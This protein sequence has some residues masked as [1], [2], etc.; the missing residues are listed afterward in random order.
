MPPDAEP[1][2]ETTTPPD[3]STQKAPDNMM[4]VLGYFTETSEQEKLP[5]PDAGEGEPAGDVTPEP[6]AAPEGDAAGEPAEKPA[7]EGEPAKPVAAVI[8]K[9]QRATKVKPS[10]VL[11]KPLKEQIADAVREG[12]DKRPES[13]TTPDPLAK[14]GELHPAEKRALELAQF[15]ARTSPEKYKDMEAKEINFITKHREYVQSVVNEK[16]T[17]TTEDAQ[18][19]EYQKLLRQHKPVYQ[20]GDREELLIQR[21]VEKGLSVAEKRFNEE[22]KA[23]DQKL[24]DMEIRPQITKVLNTIEDDILS[25]LD[26]DVAAAIKASP[27][28]A[29]EESS[30]EAAIAI[31]VIADTQASASEYLKL[32]KKSIEY[33]ENNSVHKKLVGFIQKQGEY[34]E[35]IPEANRQ[36][37]GK[38]LV[39]RARWAT[40]PKEQRPNYCTFDDGDVLDMLAVSGRNYVTSAVKVAHEKIEKSGYERKGTTPAKPATAA[41]PAATSA[42]P[43]EKPAPAAAAPAKPVTKPATAQPPKGGVSAVPGVSSSTKSAAKPAPH[44]ALSALGYDMIP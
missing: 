19:D 26:K 2:T 34:L 8:P 17:W 24:A 38:T 22:L 6:A 18:S 25:V 31:T 37:D 43:A 33:D 5:N 35:Q 21:G 36:R 12:L 7:G 13:T 39:S 28:K 1:N 30:I 3:A 15:A 44:P 29:A 32:A 23:R 42:P 41:A 40:I 20:S 14:Y 4:K 10:D 27:S 16:G 9:D 11:E